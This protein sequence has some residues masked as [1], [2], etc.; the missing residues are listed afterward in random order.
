V[1]PLVRKNSRVDSYDA[2]QAFG[3]NIP[4]VIGLRYSTPS[5]FRPIIGVLPSWY[6]ISMQTDY[7]GGNRSFPPLST[8]GI[9]SYSLTGQHQQSSPLRMMAGRH[10]CY[11]ALKTCASHALRARDF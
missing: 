1:Q 10:L 6:E 2:I 8:E 7:T 5:F 3:A 11:I 4:R 9:T